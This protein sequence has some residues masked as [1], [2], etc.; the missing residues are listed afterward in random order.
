VHVHSKRPE[1]EHTFKSI[2]PYE[3]GKMLVLALEYKVERFV[4]ASQV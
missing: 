3:Y 1:K 4:I 2:Y